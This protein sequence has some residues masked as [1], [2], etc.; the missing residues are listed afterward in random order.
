MPAY[1]PSSD[2]T[3]TKDARAKVALWAGEH[4]DGV[5]AM[6]YRLTRNRHEAEDLTQE[7]F[8]R[9]ARQN[10]WFARARICGRGSCESPSI[11]IWTCGDGSRWREASRYRMMCRQ[12]IPR[13]GSAWPAPN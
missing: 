10:D 4:W 1:L 8:L 6:L 9:A 11:P 13:H 3:L 12:P 7:T 2:L 5:F